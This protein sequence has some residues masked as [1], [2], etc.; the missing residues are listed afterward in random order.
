M[1]ACPL[2]ACGATHQKALPVSVLNKANA[3]CARQDQRIAAAESS[4]SGGYTADA[5]GAIL[6]E[7]NGLSRLR[8]GPAF[9]P[10]AHELSL[11]LSSILNPSSDRATPNRHFESARRKAALIGLKCKFGSLPAR[12]FGG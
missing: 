10:V 8:L 12:V 5:V 1:V 3:L 4:M 7:V 6:Q 11:G 2:A 9:Q